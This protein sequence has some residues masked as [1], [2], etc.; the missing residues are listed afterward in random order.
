M[1]KSIMI[2]AGMFFLAKLFILSFSFAQ[3]VSGIA[4]DQ[5]KVKQPMSTTTTAGKMTK[6]EA[7]RLGRN[8]AR[9]FYNSQIT[10]EEVDRRR[11]EIPDKNVQID[12]LRGYN[13]WKGQNVIEK[14]ER[15]Q[16]E[17]AGEESKPGY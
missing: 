17:Q 16:R 2:L 10:Q 5:G 7:E 13:T 15:K 8:T 1:K 3:P 4:S 9:Q 14:K 11:Q 6:Q 12:Y